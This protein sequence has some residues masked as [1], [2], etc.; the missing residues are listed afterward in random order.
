MKKFMALVLTLIL[1]ISLVLPAMAEEAPTLVVCWW[2]NQTRNERTQN[3]LNLFAETHNVKFDTQYMVWG[4]YWSKLA[5]QSAANE[6]PDFIQMDYKYITSYVNSDLLLDLT[7]YIESGALDIADMADSLKNVG[8]INGGIYG[9][10]NSINAPC[11][12]YNKTLMEENGI[13]V[14]CYMSLEDFMNISRQVYEKTGYKTCIDASSDWTEAILRANNGTVMYGDGYLG[15]TADDYEAF[16]SIL[17]T[18]LN[19]GWLIDNA[20]MAERIGQEQRPL[21]YGNTPAERSWCAMGWSN[22]VDAYLR[23]ADFELAMTTLP[24]NEPVASMYLKPSMLWA[25]SANCE[26]PDLAVELMNWY[27]H[28]VDCNK[29]DLAERGLPV[30]PSVSEA[31]YEDLSEANKAASAY[32]YEVVTPKCSPINPPNG[33]HTE[34]AS[35]LFVEML[36]SVAYGFM[37]ASEAATTFVEQGSAIMAQK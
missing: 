27:F 5:T 21:V 36:N 12:L 30:I 24:S 11:M 2:G 35:A 7:P 6:L 31:I 18:G 13:A 34:E 20:L 3:W 19:E 26:N 23:V 32:I 16:F 1:A 29:I 9:V 28:N 4:D 14:P 22:Q 37:T 8:N 15:G 17:E 25:I 10:A 33:L